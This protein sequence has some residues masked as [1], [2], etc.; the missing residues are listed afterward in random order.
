MDLNELINSGF[1]NLALLED[2]YA[3]YKQ[4]PNGVDPSWLPLFRQLD[5][6]R[7]ES[8]PKASMPL[9]EI[10]PDSLPFNLER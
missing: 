10:S 5:A 4:N 8:A 1:L 2:T 3:L 9:S 6:E 7:V